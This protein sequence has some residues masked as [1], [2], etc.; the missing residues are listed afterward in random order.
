MSHLRLPLGHPLCFE[1]RKESSW[2]PPTIRQDA[3]GWCEE[4]QRA[5]EKLFDAFR[6]TEDDRNAGRPLCDARTNCS[7]FVPLWRRNTLG[8][9]Q[10]GEVDS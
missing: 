10:T 7:A 9:H 6:R 8:K 4:E 2:P 3:L 1:S 5:V